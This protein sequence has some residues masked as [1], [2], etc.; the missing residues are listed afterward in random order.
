MPKNFKRDDAKKTFGDRSGRQES[1]GY[2]KVQTDLP[3]DRFQGT[4]QV[5]NPDQLG[6][7]DAPTAGS[8]AGDTKGNAAIKLKSRLK[9]AP[10]AGVDLLDGKQVGGV[11]LEAGVVTRSVA[12]TSSQSVA[13]DTSKIPYSAGG[14]RPTTRYGK[15]RSEDLFELD[16][17]VSEQ[18]APIVD[19][20]KDL[21]E[22]P[23]SKQGYNGRKQFTQT[24]AKKNYEGLPNA[25]LF[26]ASADLDIRSHVIHTT[27]QVIDGVDAQADYP[28]VNADGEAGAASPITIPMHKGNYLLEGM[29][30]TI[31]GEHIT[32]IGFTES[33]VIAKADP[34]TRDEAN[35]N[36]Q[37]DANNVTK[38]MIKM[39]TKLGRET[40]DKWTPLAYVVNQPYQYNMLMHDIEATTGAL[41]AIAY[42]AAVS[43]LAFQRN[44]V[45]KDGI[46]PQ[47]SAIRMMVEDYLGPMAN[48]NI[49]PS[50]N[51]GEMIF[52]QNA[53]RAG[54]SAAIIAMFDSTAKYRTKADLLGMQRSY[55]LH[56]SQ[57][58][59]NIDPFHVKKQFMQVLDKAHKFSTV[60]GSY[61]PMLPIYCTKE[62]KVMNP[63]SLNYFLN[64][65][66]NPA[67]FNDNDRTDIH[68]DQS[69]GTY[70]VYSYKYT[71]IRN[72][73]YTRVQHPFV[74]GLVAWLLKHEGAVVRTFG[75]G[76]VYI[77][78]HFDFMAPGLFEMMICSASQQIALERNIIFRDIL[79][80]GDQMEYIWDDLS[81][82]SE[83]D[84]LHSTQ[85]TISG[86]NEP[87]KLGKLAPDSA[88]REF[89]GSS[90]PLIKR[91]NAVRTF[92]MPWYY[93]EQAY[94]PAGAGT[95]YTNNEGFRDEDTAF[96][97]SWP[98]IRDGVR[99][100]YVDLINSMEERDVRLA[101]DRYLTIPQFTRTRTAEAAGV[102][103]PTRVIDFNSTAAALN[104]NI[105]LRSLRYDQNSDGRLIAEY[106][107]T[108][109]SNRVIE[110]LAYLCIPKELGWIWEY[111]DSFVRPVVALALNGEGAARTL[112]ATYAYDPVVEFTGSTGH[113]VRSYRVAAAAPTNGAIDR[114]A[115]L[116]QVYRTALASRD[117][118]GINADY[119]HF[120]GIALSS[121]YNANAPE[122][123]AAIMYVRGGASPTPSGLAN[124]Q[125]HSRYLW[126]L[127]QR[128]FRPV[129]DFEN[130]YIAADA[131]DNVV[132]DPLEEA[133]YFGFCGT[134]ASDYTQ[135]V[136]ERLDTFDQLGLD[137]V[138]DV[139]TKDSLIFRA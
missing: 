71:D 50:L 136:L 114:S 3:T 84:P 61:N 19:D 130:C 74:E 10:E 46:G 110:P 131:T 6:G 12:G 18:V 49:L 41:S 37:V 93:N 23:D 66:K 40:T 13:D 112:A 57:A 55:A 53:Y 119:T 134:L 115:A 30:M 126:S 139:F 128:F 78:A 20:A 51:F 113:M 31:Q 32:R 87:L 27:G 43:S 36:W 117:A 11:P 22:S 17:T 65:W 44:I 9:V 95:A 67:L 80:A 73:Y 137:Y 5:L 120:S 62:I 103:G 63:M 16:N 98:S 25:L 26:D 101:L 42:R 121:S 58:D 88:I 133:S 47:A 123:A 129:N 75:E 102:V 106:N 4:K 92:A 96:N 68:R 29:T 83:C 54:S 48:S 109:G 28:T 14:Y 24:R 116:T 35:L 1:E 60:N 108:S 111:S 127:L 52:N 45:S 118:A 79:F 82:I 125:T 91:T 100:E 2:E 64:D 56:L 138:E 70:S 81:A 34:L 85:L 94:T 124:I 90:F 69:T 77:P 104:D 39:Q 15:K 33:Q 105:T 7:A 21:R 122:N 97:M 99:H 59:N 107:M 76:D 86:Y 135:D 38:T 132:N 8:T 89:W 72:E